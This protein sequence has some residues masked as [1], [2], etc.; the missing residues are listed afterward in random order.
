V[1]TTEL[2][3]PREST[4]RSTRKKASVASQGPADTTKAYN[5]PESEITAIS[6]SIDSCWA[7]LQKYYKLIDQSPVY[8]AAV[9]LNP[10]HK[11]HYFNTH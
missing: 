2:D 5:T 6:N 9:V 11:W 7:K 3:I 4:K 8:T 1:Q 10:Q